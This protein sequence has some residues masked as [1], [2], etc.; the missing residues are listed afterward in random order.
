MTNPWT[1]NSG[2]PEMTQRQ[3]LMIHQALIIKEMKNRIM[4]RSIFNHTE[5]AVSP[6]IWEL[7]RSSPM[8]GPLTRQP[9]FLTSGWRIW[10]R[11]SFVTAG[12]R[13]LVH[14]SWMIV[15]P[16]RFPDQAREDIKLLT[17]GL[18]NV[19]STV[20]HLVPTAIML[21]TSPS[22]PRFLCYL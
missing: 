13:R 10:K 22:I 19:R 14:D 8:K 7:C 11:K 12:K 17:P 20:C 6:K 4:R 21:T 5:W 3:R 15:L 18:D 2:S 9:P 16:A 1:V